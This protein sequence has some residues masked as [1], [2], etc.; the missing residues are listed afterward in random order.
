MSVLIALVLAVAVATA[1]F[2]IVAARSPARIDNVEPA[3]HAIGAGSAQRPWLQRAL[4]SHRDPRTET[5]I[6]L[7]IAVAGVAVAIVIVGVLLEMVDSDAG[8][9]RWDESAAR[10]GA[11]NASDASTA[12]LE[13]ITHIGS[14]WFV[15]IVIAVVGVVQYRIHR[16]RAIL[17][18]LA[19]AVLTTGAVNTLVKL[20]VDRDRPDFDRLVHAGGSAFPSG[21][22][23]TAAATYAAVAFVLCRTQPRSRRIAISAAAVV[24]TIAVAASRVLLG[25]HWVTDVV[26]G[27]LVGWSCCV[28]NV[29]AFG[30]R[31]MHFGE[32]VEEAQG[33]ARGALRDRD[34]D[35]E[36][37]S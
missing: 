21:H 28:L 30:G 3:A 6:L 7:T 34:S 9:A 25:V 20:I 31:V 12:V 2:A 37:T 27:V 13:G 32:P 16:S 18:F 11:E 22:S 33:S 17:A 35:A 4:L 1:M 19:F 10:F 8:L 14:W 5:G 36:T 26:A 24:I 23:A 15:T 29:V